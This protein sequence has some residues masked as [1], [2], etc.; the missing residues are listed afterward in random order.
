LRISKSFIPLTIPGCDHFCELNKLE[1]LLQ[2]NIPQNWQ[3]ECKALN[4]NFTTP[5]I[6]GP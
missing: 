1:S 6:G 3:E 5:P 4:E 2:D